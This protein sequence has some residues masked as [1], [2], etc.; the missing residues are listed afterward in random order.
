VVGGSVKVCAI[1]G[2]VM[3]RVIL[4]RGAAWFTHIVSSLSPAVTY[5]PAPTCSTQTDRT[6]KVEHKSAPWLMWAARH[7]DA[8][9]TG[10]IVPQLLTS[11]SYGRERKDSRPVPFIPTQTSPLYSLCGTQPIWTPWTGRNNLCKI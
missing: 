1:R 10:G 3:P 6:L 11:S 7:G 4:R 8:L 5:A 9:G 2:A